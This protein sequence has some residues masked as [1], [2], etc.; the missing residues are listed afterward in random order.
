MEE[1]AVSMVGLGKMVMLG[2]A[3]FSFQLEKQAVDA[4]FIFRRVEERSHREKEPVR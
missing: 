2:N 3:Q 4:I 1:E